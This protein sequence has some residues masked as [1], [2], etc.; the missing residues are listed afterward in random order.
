[1]YLGIRF[2]AADVCSLS[3]SAVFKV[4]DANE[5]ALFC[6]IDDADVVFGRFRIE[7]ERGATDKEEEGIL[8]AE[9]IRKR[10]FGSLRLG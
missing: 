2:E 8:C 6:R 10:L 1:M 5:T 7:A 3:E 4:D 9:D